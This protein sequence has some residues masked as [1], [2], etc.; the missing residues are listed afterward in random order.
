MGGTDGR[1]DRMGGHGVSERGN[2]LSWARAALLCALFAV[3]P[4]GGIA[5]DKAAPKS[6]DAVKRALEG[7]KAHT[8][9]LARQAESLKREADEARRER[10]RA[11]RAVQDQEARVSALAGELIGLSR[12]EGAAA[13]RL[14]DNRVQAARVVMALQRLARNP[15]EALLAQP[16]D[17]ADTVR[18]AILLR[19]A[20]PGID[21][22]VA[23]LRADLDEL[24]RTR[25]QI[26]RR[27]AD[28][29]KTAETLQAERRRLDL[30]FAVKK[31]A[32]AGVEAER[33]KAKK[34]LFELAAQAKSLQE[35]IERIEHD[36][37][38]QLK[39]EKEQAARTARLAPPKA[40]RP[41]RPPRPDG[42]D[43]LAPDVPFSKALGTLPLPVVGQVV[44]RF[45]EKTDA[46]FSHKGLTL[47]TLPEAQV[48][49]PYDG[50]VVYADRFRGYGLLLILDHGEGYHSLLAGMTRIDGVPGQ[51]VLAGEPVGVMGRPAGMQPELYVE[52]RHDGQPINPTPWLAARKGKVEG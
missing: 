10:V 49:A 6:L 16:M 26:T 33:A 21:A 25:E 34:R 7:E 42:A 2:R 20:V 8:E 28:M 51:R 44:R 48:V 27:R 46:G 50:K 9:E 1:M 40:A 39:I 13:E 4:G 23:G 19:A 14:S 41:D 38:E 47:Q 18:S 5:A 43:T 30:L 24:A 31:K 45:G 3:V 17:P 35:L 37:R 12:R 15:P 36:R 22:R 11:A 32:I 52:L 29:A